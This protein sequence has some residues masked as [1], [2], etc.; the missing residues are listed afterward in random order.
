MAQNVSGPLVGFQGFHVISLD[1]LW[2]YVISLWFPSNSHESP[3]VPG[4]LC[5]KLA[6][7]WRP[8]CSGLAFGS[9]PS[10][11]IS[12]WVASSLTAPFGTW[13]GWIVGALAHSRLT[14]FCAPLAPEIS[15]P[16]WPP[17]WP[18]CAPQIPRT[19][20]FNF[21]VAIHS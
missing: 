14:S 17:C 7:L 21:F 15:W 4:N 20:V 8:S 1:L 16:S 11:E 9:L 12:F 5:V 2:N 10:F 13:M 18:P 6:S 3:P 19:T